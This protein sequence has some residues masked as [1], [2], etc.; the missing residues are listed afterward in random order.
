M[1]TLISGAYIGLEI[2]S[3]NETRHDFVALETEPIVTGEVPGRL[4][5]L[6]TPDLGSLDNG[7]PVFFRRLQVG[8]VAS[9]ALDPDGN[10]LTVTVFVR[11]PYD[12]YVNP[13]TRFWHASGIDVSLSA[14]GLTVQTQSVLSVLIG[15]IA[16]ETAASDPVLPPA[17][18][19]TVF[20]LFSNRAA[21]F[22][23]PSRNPQTYVLL[24]K[25]S[26]RGLAPGAPV[27]FRGIP[28]GEVSDV[29]AQF[30]AKTAQFS[31]PV[32]I[33]LDAQQLGVKIVDLK[34][35]IDLA[36]IRRRSMDNLIAH[37][38]R[39]QL[40][41]GNLLTGSALV[42][43]DFFPG[44]PPATIDWSQTPAQLPTIPG[45]LQ[46]MEA[47][48]QDII[49]KI[50]K[51]PLQG[52]LAIT[53]RRRSADSRSDAGERARARWRCEGNCHTGSSRPIPRRDSSWTARYRK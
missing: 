35:G 10:S 36:P 15:G 16:F 12:Q 27:E 23:A 41:T 42:A 33:H 9:Y 24:F 6:K 4:F 22:K 51:M 17:E 1:G 21:A 26:V 53:C 49:K 2:G 37:G 48:V 50:N 25:D 38:V 52:R 5:K 14:A 13:Q 43:F 40:R 45:Q 19:N 46:T 28:V 8:Q 47:S 31:V 32:T 39:A 18:A 34:P 20:T 11:A 7:T 29:S 44:A 30:D 3:S